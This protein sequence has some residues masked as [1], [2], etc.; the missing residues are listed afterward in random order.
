MI[1]YK[2]MN[3]TSRSVTLLKRNRLK[4]NFYSFDSYINLIRSF[5]CTSSLLSIKRPAAPTAIKKGP[6]LEK[7][8]LSV[9]RDPEKLVKYVCGSDYS[10]E[11]PQDV[12]IKDDS[13][14][15]DWLWNLRLTRP[16]PV[17][18]LDPNTKEYWK[19]TFSY[20]RSLKESVRKTKKF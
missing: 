10:K 20:M 18:T 4:K 19:R 14:Y 3:F 9:E 1:T 15:P 16:P 5:S 17:Y 8:K 13:E 11:N 6:M 2:M 7:Q 12:K